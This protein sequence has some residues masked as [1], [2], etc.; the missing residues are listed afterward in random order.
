MSQRLRQ[1]LIA[2]AAT[3]SLAAAGCGNKEEEVHEANT[4]GPYVTVNHL[5]YQVQISRILNPGEVEDE[6]YLRAL[7][8]GDALIPPPEDVW[9]GIFMRVEND[10]EV[11]HAPATEFEIAD[12]QEDV[13]EPLDIPFD[14]N[15]FIYDPPSE[16][17]P[18]TVYPLLN[19]A[20]SDNTIKG[21][22]LLF[23]VTTDA[24]YN[25]PIELRIVDPE[26]EEDGFINL[27]I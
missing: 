24:L 16:L 11:P 15:L 18:A 1:L 6:G 4:E 5:K 26:G 12:T 7:P 25:R 10:T 22:M 3:A 17:P 2:L 14:E 8:E 23:K 27:D 20:A 9:F 21:G 13:F 19:S